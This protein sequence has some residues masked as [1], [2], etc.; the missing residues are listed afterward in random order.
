MGTIVSHMEIMS[1]LKVETQSQSSIRGVITALHT[2][3]T[4]SINET[5]EP[6]YVTA[7]RLRIAGREALC[8]EEDWKPGE[9]LLS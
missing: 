8:R 7:M 4:S 9:S 2:N 6:I 5:N 3:A 1:R